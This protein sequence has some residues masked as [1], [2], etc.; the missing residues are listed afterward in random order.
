[1]R[2]C[3][4]WDED[5]RK[6]IIDCVDLSLDSAVGNFKGSWFVG[7]DGIATGGA[8]CVHIANITVYYDFRVVVYAQ[9]HISLVFMVRFVDDGTGGWMGS[10]Q[11][12]QVWIQNFNYWLEELFGLK[13]TFNICTSDKYLEFLDIKYRFERTGEVET[14]LFIKE[15]DSHRYLDF[16][17]N[18]PRATFRSIVYSQGIR[19]RRIISNDA[20]F[21]H[22]WRGILTTT[23]ALETAPLL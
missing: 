5:K 9:R 20:V 15:T 6:W 23:Q 21:E 17:S 2:E 13:L 8:L 7:K 4:D 19:Y 1:M 3:R 22:R 12:L 10:L 18:H 14:D 16:S 11:S